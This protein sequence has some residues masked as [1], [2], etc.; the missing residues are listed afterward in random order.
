MLHLSSRKV[1]VFNGYGDT[2]GAFLNYQL[3]RICHEKF[4]SPLYIVYHRKVN[5]KQGGTHPRFHYQYKFPAIDIERMKQ[6]AG[7]NDLFICNPV[8]STKWFGP[9]LNMKKLMY[10]QGINTYPVLD[11]FFDHYV[12]V[13]H[14]VS[15]H[16]QH[17]FN[18]KSPVI[19]PFINHS[20]F[21][22]KTPWEKRSDAILILN[23]KG[24]A[25]VA[26]DY[27]HTLY[28]EKNN[29]SKLRF[30]MIDTVVTQE[31]LASLYNQHKYFLT[32]NPNEGFGLPPLEAMASGCAVFGFDS[33]GG[34]D[35][36]DHGKN[37]FIV[38]YGDFEQLSEYLQQIEQDPDIG[39]RL[40]E[41]GVKTAQGFT[42]EN[43]EKNWTAYLTKH[44]YR[45]RGRRT[46]FSSL[47]D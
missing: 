5:R 4:G 21:Q 8:H 47:L 36:F 32:L 37:A 12:S 27:L 13:S 26:F 33:M 9:N 28:K 1:F 20:V 46:G 14:F 42:Y 3:G 18:V 15:D 31:E 40:A 16:T 35:Y 10:I 30:K 7:P 22:N 41:N 19:S 24:Y 34:R 25:K 44:V 6:I 2:G 29:H 43:F 45:E 11:I 23:Y 39:E 17:V 38:P